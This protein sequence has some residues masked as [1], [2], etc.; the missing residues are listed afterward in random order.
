VAA[1]TGSIASITGDTL[2]VQNTETESQTTVDL[3]AKTRITATVSAKLADVKAGSCITAS[4]TKGAGGAVDATT[5][6]IE[7]AVKGKCTSFGGERAG[8]PGG[9]RGFPTRTTGTGG[10]PSSSPSTFK[11]PANLDTA[12]GQVTSVSGS[13]ITVHGFSFSFS[14]STPPTTGAT[15]PT[16]GARRAIP[17]MKTLTVTVSGTTKYSKTETATAG[18]LKVGECATAFGPTNDIGAVA[19]TR[20]MVTQPT[21]AGCVP[22]FGGGRGGFGGGGGGFGG[23][24]AGGGS[25]AGAGGTTP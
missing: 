25:G 21:A 4:G 11:R 20:L 12:T 7:P 9:G 16:T 19:A 17:A 2:E 15:P 23:G 14:G 18:S 5:V 6:V 1:A 10:S 13:T 22:S 3:T 8:F 24:G